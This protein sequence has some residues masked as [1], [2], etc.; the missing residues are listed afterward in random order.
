[1]AKMTGR[2]T[3][4]GRSILLISIGVW[5]TLMLLGGILAYGQTS[6]K[7][8]ATVATAVQVTC[9]TTA[10]LA[11]AANG[12]RRSLTLIAPASNTAVVYVGFTSAVTTTTGI[13]VSPGTGLNDSTYIGT[14]YCRVAAATQPLSVGETAR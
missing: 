7:P 6:L 8:D 9:A 13:P 12:K 3:L 4:R 10:T 11:L 14:I 1:M 5:L 2:L